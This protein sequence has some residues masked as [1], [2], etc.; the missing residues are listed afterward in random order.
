[1]NPQETCTVTVRRHFNSPAEV[2]F[3]AWLDPKTAGKFLFRTP[4]GVMKKVEIDA[5]VGGKF[6]IVEIRDGLDA[7]HIGEY[8]A[9]ERPHQLCFSFGGN[10]FPTS[11]VTITIQTQQN[12]SELTLTHEAVWQ[13]Y[14]QKVIQGWSSILEGLSNIL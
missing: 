2:V 5:R 11:K 12:G 9:V 8:L 10:P 7:E 14:E 1:M 4:T 13:D 6:C 3:D